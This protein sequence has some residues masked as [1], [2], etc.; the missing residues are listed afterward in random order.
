MRTSLVPL[1]RTPAVSSPKHPPA[2]KPAMASG[3]CFNDTRSADG[4]LSVAIFV[5]T[6]KHSGTSLAES[7]VSTT[8]LK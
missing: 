2:L 3:G 6:T 7:C 4:A 1:P 5:L 8:A